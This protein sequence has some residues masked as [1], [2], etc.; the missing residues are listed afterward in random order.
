MRERG[1][2]FIPFDEPLRSPRSP[3][4]LFWVFN[5]LALQGFGGVLPIVQREIVERARWMTR[6]QFV[7]LLSACQ[8]LP[9]PNIMNLAMLFGDRWFGMRGAL[10][11]LAGMTVVPLA[12]VLALAAL[13]SRFVDVPI[14]AGA[15][16]GMG[17]VSAGLII[18]TALKM[19]TT[20]KSNPMGRMPAFFYAALTF[21]ALG[22][23]HWPMLWVVLGLG[24]ASAATAWH[25][26][27][28][29]KAQGT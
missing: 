29:T 5:R 6:D 13:Y 3:A 22:G 25:G 11:A 27:R 7:E 15:L 26:L 23:L 16:R 17:A 19:A 12:I 21:V 18:S 20:L 4:E 8:V 24:S 1:P 9:G 10:A 14:V 28:K 2:D